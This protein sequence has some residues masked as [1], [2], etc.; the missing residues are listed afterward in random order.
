[1]SSEP[2]RPR[3][4]AASG[5]A[6][7]HPSWFAVVMATGILSAG[8][9]AHVRP[10]S[11]VLLWLAAAVYLLLVVLNGWRIL[12]FAPAVRRDLHDP[13]RSFGFFTFVAGTNVLGSR[14]AAAGHVRTALGL[15]VV[16]AVAG[17][18]LGY[19]VPAGL[20]AGR[21]RP[22]IR[23]ADG[24]WF[25]W[26]VAGQS[27]ATLAAALEPGRH[28]GHDA[29]A[30]LAV[31]AW[32]VSA[33]LYVVVAV[34][35]AVRLVAHDVRP[36]DVTPPYWVAMGAAA[37][38]VL[39]GSQVARMSPAPAVDVVRDL[40]TAVSVGFWALATWL[41]PALLAAGWWRHVSHRLPLR[42]DVSWWSVVFPVAMY[43]TA[44]E[45]LYRVDQL[46]VTSLVA[47]VGI[48]IAVA[49]WTVVGL[50]TL[51][52]LAT[53]GGGRWRAGRLSSRRG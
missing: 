35:V 7:L 38:T 18:V 40:A 13:G 46:P 37:I 16:G 10:L 24:S 12:A 6:A 20:L 43:A 9:R 15:L 19:V 36:A 22:A 4:A 41:V 23:H 25:L 5:V 17:L 50:A 47:T 33:F 8:L 51:H 28:V 11:A 3:A 1:M 34:V 27:V 2:P 31:T 44:T 48:G 39:A 14:M 53:A 21:D 32:S 26:V 52:H 42:F 29:L 30:L 45:D 49:V